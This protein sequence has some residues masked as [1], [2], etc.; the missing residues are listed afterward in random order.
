MTQWNF[1]L[2]NAVPDT[3]TPSRRPSKQI[4]LRRKR[5]AS[6]PLVEQKYNTHLIHAGNS[7]NSIF[8]NGKKIRIRKVKKD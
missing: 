5:T 7:K 6:R 8:K 3:P 4:S 1:S 2:N